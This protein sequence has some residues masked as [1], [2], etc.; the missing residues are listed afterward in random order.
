MLFDL[1]N[2]ICKNMTITHHSSVHQHLDKYLLGKIF[3]NIQLIS[4]LDTPEERAGNL[5]VTDSLYLF[6]SLNCTVMIKNW[7]N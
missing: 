1:Q 2:M 4:K 6:L 3:N 5:I 7:Q